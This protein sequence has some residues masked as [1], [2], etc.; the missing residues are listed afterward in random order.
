MDSKRHAKLGSRVNKFELQQRHGT[1]LMQQDRCEELTLSKDTLQI[2]PVV[3][4]ASI[5]GFKSLLHGRVT[6]SK[7]DR[8]RAV[9]H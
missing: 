6:G 4:K 7:A 1:T 8:G 9:E 3:I 5:E 2:V